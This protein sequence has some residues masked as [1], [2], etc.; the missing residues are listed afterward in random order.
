[1]EGLVPVN[2]C[3]GRQAWRTLKTPCTLGLKVPGELAGNWKPFWLA[4]MR[5]IFCT[6][7][8]T[9]WCTTIS[10][11]SKHYL[12]QVTANHY[13]F[14]AESELWSKTFEELQLHTL[15]WAWTI[16]EK[17]LP[18]IIFLKYFTND[19]FNHLNTKLK[20]STITVL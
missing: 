3:I 15:K 19:T 5:A 2:R 9:W 6:L 12:S 1:M 4:V 7:P 11:C 8:A 13:M 14:K 16:L 10:C 18:L 17:Y 20:T